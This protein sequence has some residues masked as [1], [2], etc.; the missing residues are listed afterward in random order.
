MR[1]HELSRWQHGHDFGTAAEQHAE[2]RTRLVVALTFVTMLVELAAGWLTGSMALTADAWHMASHV[3]ALGLAATAYRIARLRAGD[4]RFT[5]GTGK[6]SSLAGYSSALLLGV[7]AGWMASES[8]QRLFIPVA[9]HYTEAMTIAVLGLVVNLASAWLLGYRDHPGPGA[10]SPSSHQDHDRGPAHVDHNLRAAYLHVLADALTSL[11]AVS[12][13]AGGM[14]FGWRRLDPL[15]GLA[16]AAV[17]ARWAWG[18][19]RETGRVLL[20][21]EDHGDVAAEIRRLIETVPDHEVADLHVWRIGTASRACIVSLVTHTPHSTGYY[22][23]LLAAIP[24]LDHVTV[25]ISECRDDDCREPDGS[26]GP[27]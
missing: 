7:V 1:T 5:F 4:A 15:M 25:E 27:V 19:A 13:L 18:L 2:R 8:V 22:R 11:L 24:G 21:A 6:V 20:D 23:E 17:I 3:A 12:A 10:G 9:I 26:G 16:G 14:A